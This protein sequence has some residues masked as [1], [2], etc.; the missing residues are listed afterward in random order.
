[1]KDGDYLGIRLGAAF[2][3]A[4]VLA[5]MLFVGESQLAAGLVL[6][7]AFMGATLIIE[8]IGARERRK[9]SERD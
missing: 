4:V 2:A 3:A 5:G 1:M 6:L 7:V 8:H 9:R